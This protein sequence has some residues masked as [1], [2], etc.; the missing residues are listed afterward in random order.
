MGFEQL[1]ANF[2]DIFIIQFLRNSTSASLALTQ[3]ASL[4][5]S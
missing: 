3:K 1:N 2:G 5:R 4:I